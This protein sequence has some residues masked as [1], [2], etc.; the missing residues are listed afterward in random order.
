MLQT[1]AGDLLAPCSMPQDAWSQSLAVGPEFQVNTVHHGLSVRGPAWRRTPPA[2][3]VVVWRA[4]QDGSDC[5]VF[6]AMA[7]CDRQHRSGRRSSA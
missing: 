2:D 7:R 5:G 4:V 1:C 6:R 3:F